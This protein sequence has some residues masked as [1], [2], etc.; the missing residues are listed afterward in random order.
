MTGIITAVPVPSYSGPSPNTQ[1]I[2]NN[3]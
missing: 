3:Q 1:R 2:N